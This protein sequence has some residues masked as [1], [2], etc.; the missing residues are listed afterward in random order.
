MIQEANLQWQYIDTECGLIMPWYVL[1]VLKWLKE[2]PVKDW[3][4]FE[5][6]AGYSTV[7]WRANCREIKGVES[8]KSWAKAMSIDHREDE[9]EYVTHIDTAGIELCDCVVIDGIYREN[10]LRYAIDFMKPGGILIVD[11]WES[12]DFDPKQTEEALKG[13]KCILHKQPNHSSWKTAVLIKP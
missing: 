1:P 13:W 9:Y 8:S 12:E 7:W 5:Y 2:Q 3:K 4:V 6:G 11:N 10:C